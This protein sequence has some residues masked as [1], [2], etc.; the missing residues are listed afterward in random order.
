MPI[1]IPFPSVSAEQWKA[2]ILKDLKGKAYETLRWATPEGFVLEPF[3]TAEDLETLP[4]ETI[5]NAQKTS[6]GWLNTPPFTVRD[7]RETNTRLRRAASRGA[8]AL[9]LTLP[10]TPTDL[11]RLL[12]GLKLSDTPVFFRVTDGS[13]ADVL[14]EKLVRIAPYQLKG[15]LLIDPVY[16]HFAHAISV[17]ENYEALAEATRRAAGFPQFRTISVQSQGFH[18]A[19]ATITQELAFTLAALAE[20]YDHLTDA[21]LEAAQLFSKTIVSVSVG[22]SF[23][24]EIAKLRA[25]RLLLQRFQ[26]AWGVAPQPVFVHAQTSPFYYAAVEP[27]TNLLRATTEAMAAVIGGCDALTVHPHDAALNPASPSAEAQE[28]SDRIARNISILLKDESHLG[29]VADP[30]AG[31]YALEQLTHQ[32]AEQAWA[33]FLDMENRGGLTA[34]LP[35]IREELA[36]SYAAKVEALRTGRVMVGVNKYRAE[37]TDAAANPEVGPRLASEFE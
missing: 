24:P 31:A 35:T 34:A 15:G 16:N 28:F 25:L 29:R 14:L 10:N 20:Q 19:G 17:G 21:G 22:T 3:Y 2:Q 32:L 27:Y 1:P 6:G 18:H 37:E 30:A 11:T 4:L 33:L 23:F 5:Q 9:L 8:D 36:R 12:D 13:R 26:A 7:D